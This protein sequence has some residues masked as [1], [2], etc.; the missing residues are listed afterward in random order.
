MILCLYHTAVFVT[1]SMI[2][3]EEGRGKRGLPFFLCGLG[4]VCDGNFGKIEMRGRLWIFFALAAI[5]LKSF[6]LIE[7]RDWENIF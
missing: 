7:M 3:R 4:G 2:E 5:G 1:M 6:L